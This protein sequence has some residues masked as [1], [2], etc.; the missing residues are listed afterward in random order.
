M[1]KEKEVAPELKELIQTYILTVLSAQEP[2]MSA[3][4][5]TSSDEIAPEHEAFLGLLRTLVRQSVAISSQTTRTN[6]PT[7]LFFGV[8]SFVLFE[9]SIDVLRVENRLDAATYSEHVKM[10]TDAVLQLHNWS[11]EEYIETLKT[12]EQQ[13]EANHVIH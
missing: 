12:H 10:I 9:I 2:T 11:Y 7:E 8:M 4:Q 5:R 13:Q 6:I 1:K 3:H